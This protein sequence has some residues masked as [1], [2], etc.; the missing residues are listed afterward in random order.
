VV[1]KTLKIF[2]RKD[3]RFEIRIPR[4]LS[5]SGNRESKYFRTRTEAAEFTR[6]F[7]QERREHGRQIVTATE[8]RWLGYW[9]ERVGSLELMPDVVRFYK[10]S[11]ENL[12]PIATDAAMDL[13]LNW[14]DTEYSNPR[15]LS[16]IVSRCRA[17]GTHFGTRPLHEIT[18]ADIEAYLTKY[19]G[20]T[21]W[22]HFKRLRV[23]TKYARRQ[24]WLPVDPMLELQVPRTPDPERRVYTPEE[25]QRMLHT[26]EEIY[27]P[28]LPF[29]V[30]SG[31]CFLRTAEL[32]RAYKSEKVLQWEHVLWEENFIWVPPGV[33]KGTRRQSDKRYIPLSEA[34][35][36]WLAKYRN[37]TG[38][39]VKVGN[40]SKWYRELL[41][42]AN[43]PSIPNGLRH[44]CISYSIAANP[45]HGQAKTSEWAGNSPAAIKKHYRRTI[46]PSEAAKWFQVPN[47][48][49]WWDQLEA[50]YGK[51]P[52]LPKSYEVDD[53]SLSD[54]RDAM[55]RV[56]EGSEPI[57]LKRV[58]RGRDHSASAGY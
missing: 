9:R 28:L 25:F 26:A 48:Q 58:K 40:F 15:T 2:E 29:I 34:A 44:S 24:R 32:I 39:C 27:R 7:E 12:K 36:K 10:H 35:Q 50:E 46:K 3:G 54:L 17:F 21:R 41:D 51:K 55:K 22:A 20:W 23:F 6:Q 57:V 19:R 43:A 30:L 45:E 38:D 47:L 13:F 53:D 8:R 56:K 5:P 33:A 42:E 49:E 16:D 31:F 11:G 52:Q 1:V 18:V 4:K 14:A 37:E